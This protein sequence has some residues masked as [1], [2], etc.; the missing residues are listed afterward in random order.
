L[1]LAAYGKTP[2]VRGAYALMGA[3]TAVAMFADWM[4]LTWSRHA[5]PGPADVRSQLQTTAILL[6]R[7]ANLLKTGP[8]WSAPIFLGAAL[9]SLWIYQERSHAEADL[10]WAIVGTAWV[11]GSVASVAK[12]KRIDERRSRVDRML[13]DWER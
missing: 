1:W 2:L 7:Q 9:V 4:Y 3:G 8:L 6:G 13:A 10:L 12:G 11:V 5:I